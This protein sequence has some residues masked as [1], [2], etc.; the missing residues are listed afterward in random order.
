MEEKFYLLE[1][2]KH[3]ESMLSGKQKKF[4]SLKLAKAKHIHVSSIYDV[5]DKETVEY[6]K[7]VVRPKPKQCFANAQKFAMYFPA[8]NKYVEGEWGMRG[9]FGIEHAFNCI[10]GVYVDITAELVLGYDVTKEDYLSIIEISDEKVLEYCRKFEAYM[11]LVPYELGKECG[12]GEE[13][14]KHF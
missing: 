12:L 6:I 2:M 11:S 14:V 1:N 4:W 8:F 5:F 10:N 7:E 3:I 9:C 13:E